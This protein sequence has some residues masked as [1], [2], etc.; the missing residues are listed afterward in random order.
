MT[1]FFSRIAIAR[2]GL[3]KISLRERYPAQAADERRH[4]AAS[5]GA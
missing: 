4:L 5:A 3:D 1:R 2:G